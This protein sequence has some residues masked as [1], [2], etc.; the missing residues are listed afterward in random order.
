[1]HKENWYYDQLEIKKETQEEEFS[2][3]EYKDD[4]LTQYE[5]GYNRT[6]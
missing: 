6:D 4:I 1:M 5:N 3:I 2:T